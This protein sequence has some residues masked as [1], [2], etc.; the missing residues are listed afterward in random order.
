VRVTLLGTGGSA[1]VPLVSPKPGG[2]WGE[3]DP[4]DPR[5][6]RTRTSALVEVGGKRILI[7][8]GPDLRTQ[9]L[10]VG[11]PR[12]DAVLFTHAHA[13]HV[14]GIDDLRQAN[15]IT[16]AAIPAFADAGT[17]AELRER[18]AYA[19][20][21]HTGGHF[22]RPVLVP[23]VIVPGAPFDAA[24]VTVLPIRQDH[25]FGPSLGFRIGAFAYSTDVLRLDEAAFAALEG[26]ELWVVG[27]FRRTWHP[28]HATLDEV[29]GWIA[30]LSPKRAVLTQMGE[31]LDFAATA[32]TLPPGAE[33]GFDGWSADVPDPD[34]K[35]P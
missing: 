12:L 23:Q 14:A 27:C 4:A 3:C 22:A 16:G 13:D 21:P 19:L 1:G 31:D 34:Q 11:A 6:R 7:D 33:P 2:F 30:R 26:V 20:A 9:L 32:A 24:G 29:M 25:G 17:M 5:N 18:F 15:R 8:A 35:I 28:G 10:M